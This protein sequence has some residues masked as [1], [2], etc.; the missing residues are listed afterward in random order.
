LG[1]D[2]GIGS[3][4][5]TEHRNKVIGA[6]FIGCDL[7]SVTKARAIRKALRDSYMNQGSPGPNQ[8]H[9]FRSEPTMDTV[10]QKKN[11]S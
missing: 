6:V 8:V 7:C 5:I 11:C 4:G 2:K 1:R 9:D 10:A 3:N